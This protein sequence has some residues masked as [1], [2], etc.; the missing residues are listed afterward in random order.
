MVPGVACRMSDCRM[1]WVCE[2]GE[3]AWRARAR[4]APRKSNVESTNLVQS[5][6]CETESAVYRVCT[7]VLLPVFG[8]CTGCTDGLPL[9]ARFSDAFRYV[10][11]RRLGA[12]MGAARAIMPDDR[13]DQYRRVSYVFSYDYVF[14]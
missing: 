11:R 9:R 3:C 13:T 2:V 7:A 10:S 5:F 4:R 12:A 1:R 14:V 8:G 6:Y